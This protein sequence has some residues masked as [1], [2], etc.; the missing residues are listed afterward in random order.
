M[1]QKRGRM[2]KSARKRTKK[3]RRC[4]NIVP[5]CRNVLGR[6]A[7]RDGYGMMLCRKCASKIQG[8]DE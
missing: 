1:K 4:E 5:S 3:R 2:S 7:K 8:E 6:K